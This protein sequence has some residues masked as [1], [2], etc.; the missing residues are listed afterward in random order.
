MQTPSPKRTVLLQW[1]TDRFVCPRKFE[2]PRVLGSNPTFQFPSILTIVENA[3]H[4][5]I[6]FVLEEGLLLVNFSGLHP[7]GSLFVVGPSEVGAL[8]VVLA[9]R[10]ALLRR[11]LR[12]REVLAVEVAVVGPVG[13]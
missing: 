6:A 4:G 8:R 1:P 9:G 13:I 10:A 7:T 2:S 11:H 12:I 5:A 3:T